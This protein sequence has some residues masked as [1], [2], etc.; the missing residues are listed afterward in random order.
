VQRFARDTWIVL[1][2]L[3]AL[4]AASVA[5]VYL[6]QNRKL[7]KLG[8]Q[9]TQQKKLLSANA[10]KASG[11]PDML[12]RIREMKDRYKD[13]D[14]RLPKR[15]ELGEFLHEI[16]SNLAGEKLS[17]QLIEPGN[18]TSQPLF[19]KLPIIMRFGGSYPALASFLERIDR[20]ERLTRVQ[21]LRI[22]TKQ[23]E[24]DLQIELQ[25]N[26]YFTES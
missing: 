1:G 25:M 19:H 12:R 26:I 16:S 2:L 24:T 9:I 3:V 6:P 7:Q 8:F 20:M 15:K 22:D 13:F 14:R 4:V 21:R 17:N 11:V 18:P 23:G 5:L 10:E